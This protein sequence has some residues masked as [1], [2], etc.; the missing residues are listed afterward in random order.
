M[1]GF[2]PSLP[3]FVV[4]L[5]LAEAINV[6]TTVKSNLRRSRLLNPKVGVTV[7]V[8]AK[9][10]YERECDKG[11]LMPMV[12]AGTKGKIVEVDEEGE[13]AI[14]MK[15]DNGDQAWVPIRGLVGYESWVK[16]AP[17]PPPPAPPPP[18]GP[19]PPPP[20]GTPAPTTVDLWK[21]VPKDSP[22]HK[23]PTDF[24]YS[25]CERSGEVKHGYTKSSGMTVS[26]C[27]NHCRKKEDIRYFGLTKGGVCFCSKLPIGVKADKK[28]CDT[29]CSGNQK[30][31][32][33]GIGV[34]N[35]YTLMSCDEP[36]SDHL[37]MQRAQMLAGLYESLEGQSCGQTKNNA[38]EIAGSAKLLGTVNDCK[39]ACWDGKGAKICHGF[40]YD[41]VVGRC[42][43]VQDVSDGGVKK[44]PSKT[45]YF[46]K[47]GFPYLSVD[48]EKE[49]EQFDKP[50]L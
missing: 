3:L 40:E 39:L 30:E 17:A 44:S 50:Y 26:K 21:P 36:K 45:C 35:V 4:S 23:A 38:V 43:F 22:I 13:G 28:Q 19:P 10:I 1:G 16:G 41:T 9:E 49:E 31:H 47:I 14:L 34:A 25:G 11:G 7:T 48:Q 20:P 46:K 42:K 15:A 32:C 6:E 27:F 2:A 24:I 12:D 18:P 29:K 5:L 33:G 8:S 37:A